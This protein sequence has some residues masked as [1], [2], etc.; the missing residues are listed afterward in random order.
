MWGQSLEGDFQDPRPITGCFTREPNGRNWGCEE[1]LQTDV[2]LSIPAEK[3]D[4][5]HIVGDLEQQTWDKTELHNLD[6]VSGD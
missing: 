5:R 6:V 3:Y 1:S 2:N 4:L